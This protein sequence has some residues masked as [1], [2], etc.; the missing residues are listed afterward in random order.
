MT[1]LLAI[2]QGTT[3]TRAIV[4][5]REAQR[6]GSGQREMPQSYPQGGW[7]EH[8]PERIWQDTVACVRE[9][10]AASGLAATAITAIGITNQRETTVVWER[11]S[12]RPIYPAI[13]WQDRRTAQFC[14]QHAERDAWIA[15]RTGLLLDPYFSAT[16]IAW[17]LEHVDG[18]RAR[19]Q[20]GEL[21]FGTIDSWLIWKLTAGRRHV[22]AD[23]NACRTAQFHLEQQDWD[24]EL[25]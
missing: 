1:A 6:L 4:F 22:T 20:A 18:A 23:T 13:V 12:G 14:R 24:Q 8:D 11:A 17:I 9:A 7:V 16:K 21:A 25:I 5:D 10:L 2:D 15:S 19:A 3:S